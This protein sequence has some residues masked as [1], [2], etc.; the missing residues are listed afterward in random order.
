MSASNSD[1]QTFRLS[2]GVPTSRRTPLRVGGGGSSHDGYGY[3]VEKHG[4]RYHS[5][6][7]NSCFTVWRSPDVP[8]SCNL[9]IGIWK[10]QRFVRYKKQN[11]L[12]KG[13]SVFSSVSCCWMT[14][15]R[16]FTWWKKIPEI[17]IPL[18]FPFQKNGRIQGVHCGTP[19]LVLKMASP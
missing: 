5:Q 6:T 16:F 10:F 15:L 9:K 7:W 18:K 19:R 17:R 14:G 13:Q 11:Q 1:F 12:G 8:P 4:D 2:E 3:V